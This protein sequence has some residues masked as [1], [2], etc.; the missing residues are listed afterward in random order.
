MSIKR[1]FVIGI[2]TVRREPAYLVKTVR[3]L[4]TNLRPVDRERCCIVIFDAEER[5]GENPALGVIEK[6]FPDL[7]ESSFITYFRRHDSLPPTDEKLSL[8][9]RWQQ[10]QSLDCAEL[11]CFCRDL[12]EYYLHVED[13]V[14]ACS[15]FLEAIEQC[16]STHVARNTHWSV[17]SFYNSYQMKSD[18]Y[19]TGAQLKDR[20]FGL[21]GQLIRCRDLMDLASY[22]TEHYRELPVDVLVGRFVLSRGGRIYGHSPALFQHVGVISSLTG[23]TQMWTAP[24][25]HEGYLSRTLRELRGWCDVINHQPRSLRSYVFMKIGVGIRSHPRGL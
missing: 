1:K 12:G 19:Y 21:I 17:L 4:V 8:K 20:Y 15:G 3:S 11:F 9:A 25:F 22:V 7:F 14:V 10:K 18:E 6:T 2:P 23:R 5:S 24:D 16:L 13:D